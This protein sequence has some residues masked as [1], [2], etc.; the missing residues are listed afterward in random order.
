MFDFREL[1]LQIRQVGNTYML[2]IGEHRIPLIGYKISS[3]EK[4]V[5]L[6]LS[7]YCNDALDES[8]EVQ[9]S[10]YQWTLTSLDAAEPSAKK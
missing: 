4:G 1:G 7:I 3:F 6:D 10:F 8:G 9:P 2:W 5:I